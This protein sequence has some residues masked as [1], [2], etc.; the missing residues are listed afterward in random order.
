MKVFPAA[1]LITAA[2]VSVSVSA[3]TT[4]T[5]TTSTRTHQPR[6]APSVPPRTKMML[7]S[8]GNPPFPFGMKKS[9]TKMNSSINTDTGIS[10]SMKV[11]N[12][13]TVQDGKLKRILQ[14]R[15]GV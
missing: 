8:K 11:S 1:L 9:M 12:A 10:M 2:T 7:A 15:V 5:T 6:S 14:R 4:T 13:I 3:F